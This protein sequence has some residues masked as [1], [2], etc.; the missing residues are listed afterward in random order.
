MGLDNAYGIGSLKPGV[1]TSS[2]RPSAP[3][4]GQ[5]IYETDTDTTRVWDGSVW[6][7]IGTGVF[8]SSTRPS[9]PY[10]G[11]VIYETDTDKL[12]VYNGSAWKRFDT[13]YVSWTPTFTNFSLGN[14]SVTTVYTQQGEF[15]HLIGEVIMGSTSTFTGLFQMTIPTV[16]NSTFDGLI[17]TVF[18]VD[19]G[20][21]EFVGFAQKISSTAIIVRVMNAG[22]TYVQYANT[23]GTVP[24]TWGSGDKLSFNLTYRAA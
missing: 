3:F 16:H 14:G 4:D 7:V 18:L 2:T 6:D 24:F 9:S 22:G 23:S 15:V 19:V 13:T 11:K 17:G 10:E 8:T 20:V 5:V 21:Q 1:C 12:A